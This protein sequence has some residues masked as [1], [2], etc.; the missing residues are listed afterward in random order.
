M[1]TLKKAWY[2]I[3][4]FVFNLCQYLLPRRSP[5]LLEGPGS[6]KQL[7]T[8]IQTKG[9]HKVLIVTDAILPKIGLL[10]N[11]FTACS[12]AGLNYVLYDGAQVNPSIECIEA[13][14]DRYRENECQAFI[15]FGGGSSMD[16]AKAAAARVARPKRSIQELG[17]TLKVL[18][19]I[20]MI[21]AVPT[22]AGT[23]SETTVAA[24]VTDY[25]THHKYAIQDPCLIPHVAVLDAELTVGLPPHITATTG[26]DALTHAVEAYPNRFAPQYTDRLA[27]KAVKLIFDN[28][29]LAYNDGA[30]ITARQNMLRASFYAGAAFSRAC[31]G[32]VHAI[33]HTLG[34]LYGTAHGLA[35]AVILPYVLEDFGP[36]VYFKLARLAEIAG[37][38]GKDDGEKARAFIDAIRQLNKDM[39]IIDQFDFILDEDIPQMV[40]WALKEANPIYPVPV[41]WDEAQMI[42]T[43]SRVRRQPVDDEA[44]LGL[45]PK[46]E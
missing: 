1:W 2:R 25:S 6:I 15:A 45:R 29:E 46:S 12:E 18:K 5:E 10:D 14:F 38:E 19:K 13:A 30:N 4:Q 9:I 42:R 11:L 8:L 43:I 3:F 34:G 17:G 31:V 40:A 26:M 33:A 41:I 23:G 21:F 36:A 22:T 37:V 7:P 32:N 44:T 24:V 39:N 20:P 28:L 16:C 27:E 35:N